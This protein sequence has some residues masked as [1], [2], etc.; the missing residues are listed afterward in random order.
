[1]LEV[2]GFLVWILITLGFSAMPFAIAGF[3][4]LA[5]GFKRSDAIVCL[6]FAGLSI[7]SWYYIFLYL[8][9]I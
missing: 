4:G 7:T 9:S 3:S 6:A 5:G 8:Q 1:M 2:I